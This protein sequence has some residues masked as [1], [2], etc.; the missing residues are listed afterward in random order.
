[1]FR[2]ESDDGD[3]DED[4]IEIESE[5]DE[6]VEDVEEEEWN[7]G[8]EKN[9]AEITFINPSQI[10]VNKVVEDTLN[11]TVDEVVNETA[12]NAINERMDSRVIDSE[13]LKCDLCIFK[14]TD[15]IRFERHKF[16]NHSVRGK[17][18]CIQCLQEFDK[19]KYF[20]HHNYKGCNSPED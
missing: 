18:K 14:T 15:K 6:E 10:D 8:N 1:M 17:Y 2:H 13:E 16:E 3:I 4:V 11:L 7:V 19:R 20:N 9:A 5:P 12:Q